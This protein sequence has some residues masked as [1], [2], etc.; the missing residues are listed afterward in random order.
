[1]NK[2][3]TPALWLITLI[4]GLSQFSETVYTP[5]LPDIQKALST[6]ATLTEYTITIYLFAFAIG[7][8]FWGIVSDKV[9]RKPSLL[10]GFAFYLIGCVG[11]YFSNT[12]EMLL[13]AR[14]VQAFGG[15]VGSVLG[16]AICRDVFQGAALSKAYALVGIALSFFPAIGPIIGG[17][18]AEYFIWHNIFLLLTICAVF[19]MV[20]INFNLAETHPKESRGGVSAIKTFKRMACDKKVIGY[21]LVIGIL[22][23]IGFSYFAEGSFYFIELLGLSPSQYGSTFILISLAFML[24]GFASK[25]LLTRMNAISII[26]YGFYTMLMGALLFTTFVFVGNH[27]YLLYVVLLSIMLID[28]G[29]ILVNSIALSAALSEYKNCIGTASSIFGFAYYLFISIFT[30]IMGAL[31]NGTLYPMP[32]YFLFLI[33]LAMGVKRLFIKAE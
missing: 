22:N 7:V 17:V 5:S 26:Q 3:L 29:M 24:G 30:L 15:S 10:A 27:N 8:L 28:F 9:G 19:V 16:Q 11:C 32:L 20:V 14:F 31:H 4:V 23:G 13:F 18:I 12:I 6:T 33:L 25:Y 21:S 2:T 1:M